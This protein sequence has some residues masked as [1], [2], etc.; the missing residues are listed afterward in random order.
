MNSFLRYFGGKSQLAAQIVPRIPKHKTYIEPFAGAAWILFSKP[1]SSVEIINDL[2][3][4]L[5]RLY[6]CVKHHF[7]ELVKQFKWL[8]VSREEFDRIRELPSDSLTDI[9]ASARFLFLN[10]LAYN[11]LM[12][13][14]RFAVSGERRAPL[15][16]LRL[17]ETLSEA[18][19]RLSRVWIE[20][21]DF[22]QC[23]ERFDAP[24]AFFYVDPPYFKRE[25]AYG[26]GLFVRED[27]ERLRAQLEGIQGKFLLSIDS[28]PEMREV[29]A[30]FEVE[31]VAAV[32]SSKAKDR[33]VK[34]LLIRNYSL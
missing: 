13:R 23:I 19:L 18:H 10:R 12:D 34:E 25:T 7:E 1:E 14:P 2:N 31:E 21:M 3:G 11:G 22:G 26:K 28:S 16:L 33:N 4:D 24:T 5:V 17:E 20:R 32:W 30:Q 27:F 29:F 8:L 15:N 9:Q 6:R